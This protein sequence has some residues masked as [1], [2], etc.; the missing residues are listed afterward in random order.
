MNKNA[1]KAI[2]AAILAGAGIG[3]KKYIDVRKEAH[4]N[5][6]KQVAIRVASALDKFTEEI[7][8]QD[9]TISIVN[10]EDPKSFEEVIMTDEEREKWNASLSMLFGEG[11]KSSL[12]AL[13]SH[14]LLKCDLPIDMLVKNKQA[15]EL[16]RGYVIQDGKISQQANFMEAGLT[17]AQISQLTF[18]CLSVITSQYY[19][20]VI[21]NQLS[22]ISD[23]IDS[24]TEYLEADDRATVIS[25]F[26]SIMGISKKTTFTVEDFSFVRERCHDI[27]K[28]R[29][30]YRLLIEDFTLKSQ[31]KKSNIDEAEYLVKTLKNSHFLNTLKLAYHTDLMLICANHCLINI[32]N[33]LGRNEDAE[34]ILN[35]LELDLW[36]YYGKKLVEIKT[37]VLE[38][39]KCECSESMKIGG[40]N[41]F[42]NKFDKLLKQSSESFSEIEFDLRTLDR[43]IRQRVP[44]YIGYTADGKLLRYK[45]IEP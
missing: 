32:A 1:L 36:Q 17:K 23:K 14:G 2:G 11:L 13:G 38:F 42:K 37:Y 9:P 18:Q 10:M 45:K 4:N 8:L 41:L 31:W 7:V 5:T 25:A 20:N 19:L 30:K 35:R 21:N 43:Q 39:I 28:V 3:T 34:V 16:M 22:Q 12:T 6:N 27:E 40:K 33:Y 26:C 24:I 29:D 44:E 15:P